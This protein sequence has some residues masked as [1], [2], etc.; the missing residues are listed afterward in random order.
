MPQARVA[1][2]RRHRRVVRQLAADG[3]VDPSTVAVDVQDGIAVLTGSVDSAVAK[4]AAQEAAHRVPGVLDVVNHVALRGS[5]GGPASDVDLCRAVRGALRRAVR[6]HQRIRTS[7]ER[8]WVT[9]CGPVATVEERERAERAVERIPGVRG[10]TNGLHVVAL[11][12]PRTA[13]HR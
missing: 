1:D 2:R 11:S 5:G 9:L 7:V 6:D 4:Q 8:G 10:V 13:S 3:R 12:D